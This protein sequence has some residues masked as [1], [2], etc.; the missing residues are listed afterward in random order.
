MT[1][2]LVVD[3][4][5]SIRQ[6]VSSALTIAGFDVVEA[7]D[8]VDAMT[9]L[10]TG[11]GVMICDIGMPR[12]D[13]LTML[14]QIRTDHRFKDLPVLMLTTQGRPDLMARARSAGAKGWITKPFKA[15]LL[16]AAVR[17]LAA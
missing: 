13:G 8:G 11:I 16:V 12:L 1:R 5:A 15:E 14:E 6:M 7:T 4:S 9:K 17:Q 10:P 3:D 2:V